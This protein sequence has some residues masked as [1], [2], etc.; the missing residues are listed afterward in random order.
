[1]VIKKKWNKI[2]LFL[3]GCLLSLAVVTS[4]GEDDD[5]DSSSAAATVAQTVTTD[6]CFTYDYVHPD[7]ACQKLLA[8]LVIDALNKKYSTSIKNISYS[9]DATVETQTKIASLGIN[10]IVVMGDSLTSGYK[11]MTAGADGTIHYF[12]TDSYAILLA[13]SLGLTP[14][15][16]DDAE[17]RY[18]AT[19]NTTAPG[20]ITNSSNTKSFHLLGFPSIPLSGLL[21][22]NFSTLETV[23]TTYN[24]TSLTQRIALW[25]QVLRSDSSKSPAAQ[26][27]E[28]VPDLLVINAGNIDLLSPASTENGLPLTT[29]ENFKTYYEGVIT[30]A[31]TVN[32]KV[33]LVFFKIANVGG[34][35]SFDLKTSYNYMDK[36]LVD[37]K[38]SLATLLGTTL[39]GT[40]DDLLYAGGTQKA[41]R[42]LDLSKDKIKLTALTPLLGGFGASA[43]KPLTDEYWLSETELTALNTAY[44]NYNSAITELQTKYQKEENGGLDVMVVDTADDLK[45]I[46]TSG[47][48]T[49]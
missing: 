6:Q 49:K 2:S 18:P 22:T 39:Y 34:A 32:P 15:T 46:T 10:K 44:T 17:F 23:A 11:H 27:A 24:N 37:K 38:G 41:A 29:K 30:Y 8:N 4:C 28:L 31:K 36:L 19:D 16:G 14:G 42:A 5:D 43:D 26:M 35:P 1:M 40:T 3:G 7:L 13:K 33:K 45:T 20:T 9:A 21:D 25:R 48:V 12:T 47:S